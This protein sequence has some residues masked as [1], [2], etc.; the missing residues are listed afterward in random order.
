MKRVETYLP[1]D[2][3]KRLSDEAQS[4]GIKR[5]ELIRDLILNSQTSFDITPDDYNR[6]VVRIRKRC[7]NLLGRHQ[8]ESLVASVFTEFSGASLRAAKN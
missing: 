8:A 1:E 6:A 3:A 7:G 2:I 5:S 4:A